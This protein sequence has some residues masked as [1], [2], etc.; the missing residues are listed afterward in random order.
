MTDAPR[1]TSLR[2]NEWQALCHGAAAQLAGLF[3]QSPNLDE[4]AYGAVAE[5]VERL[6]MFVESWRL[7]CV[8][9]PGMVERHEAREPG[10]LH[11]QPPSA[12]AA[13]DPDIRWARVNGEPFEYAIQQ[14]PH[15][16][17]FVKLADGSSL[18]RPIEQSADANANGATEPKRKGG[19]PKGKPRKP[20]GEPAGE[21]VQ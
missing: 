19:W 8:S 1:T 2:P 7:T 18:R 5:H 13:V 3:A 11:P 9:A 6:Q 10:H 12:P 17:E 14:G 4:A 20:Q 21:A 16:D 15:G